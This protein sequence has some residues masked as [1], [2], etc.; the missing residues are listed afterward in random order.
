[1]EVGKTLSP[2]MSRMLSALPTSIQNRLPDIQAFR[3]SMSQ[4]TK[5]AV[6][7]VSWSSQ[8][9]TSI[10]ESAKFGST[11]SAADVAETMHNSTKR[12]I[13]TFGRRSAE[14]EHNVDWR[15]AK[16]GLDLVVTAGRE[17]T[18]WDD[19]DFSPAFER[20]S[21]I[22]GVGYMLQGLPKDLNEK[23]LTVLYQHVSPRQAASLQL[24]G[25]APD[26]RR[27][28]GQMLEDQENIVYRISFLVLSFLWAITPNPG[29]VI[30]WLLRFEREH[31]FIGRPARYTVKAVEA[32]FWDVAQ[33]RAME[34]Q[35]C[36][37]KAGVRR[38]YSEE[39][40]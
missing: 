1:M 19:H 7:S 15:Y 6:S 34:G 39:Y 3:R 21:Y 2:G 14:P 25:H 26:Q 13:S 28:R 38:E 29:R 24:A 35:E 37:G 10:S 31:Q 32:A 33:K 30:K 22:T 36:F 40:R 11:E 20:S 5:R 8:A 27:S 23:D 17:S 18:R 4:P 12:Y 9:S 16:Q